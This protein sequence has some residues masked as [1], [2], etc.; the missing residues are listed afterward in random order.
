MEDPDDK[1]SVVV[2]YISGFLGLND[3]IE[4]SISLSNAY[5]NPANYETSISYNIEQLADA[6]IIIHN[7]L[8]SEVKNIEL[9]DSEGIAKINVSDLREGVYFYSLMID[10]KLFETRKLMIKR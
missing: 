1:V 8:G 2:N 6:R 7:L 10:E 4:E 3:L 9:N 5:P